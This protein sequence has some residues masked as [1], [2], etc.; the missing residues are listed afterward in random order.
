MATE[1]IIPVQVAVRIRPLNEKENNEGCQ[2]ALEQVEGEPQVRRIGGLYSSTLFALVI[3]HYVLA[4][5][6]KN[7]IL[8]R[9]LTVACIARYEKSDVRSDLFN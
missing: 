6:L 8:Q 2:A 1:K 4:S 3:L 7:E 5:K 9:K